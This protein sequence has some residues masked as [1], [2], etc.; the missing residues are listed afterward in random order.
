MRACLVCAR[1][2]LLLLGTNVRAQAFAELKTTE[3]KRWKWLVCGMLLGRWAVA[4]APSPRAQPAC[5]Q[6]APPPLLVF[7]CASLHTS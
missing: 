4:R 2:L 6:H 3:R 5:S 7:Y 1:V